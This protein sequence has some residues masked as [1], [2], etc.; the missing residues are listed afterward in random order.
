MP[1]TNAMILTIR[2]QPKEARSLMEMCRRFRFDD[3]QAF[4]SGARNA[5][6]T[7]LC[8]AVTAVLNALN[9]AGGQHV[10]PDTGPVVAAESDTTV[11]VALVI[12]KADLARHR[13]FLETLLA[14]LPPD[15][16]PR[17]GRP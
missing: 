8:E 16:P 5:D 7:S 13:Q 12:D 17:R 11:T 3:A 1:G 14:V 4:L 6:A 2:L 10:R 15:A 9:A